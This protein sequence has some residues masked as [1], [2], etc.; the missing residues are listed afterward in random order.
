VTAILGLVLLVAG[1]AVMAASRR[2]GATDE[3]TTAPRG[4]AVFL[5]GCVV[6][7]VG[8]VLITAW[9]RNLSA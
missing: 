7:A 2:V 3:D 6:V 9:W 4:L 1:V 5:A 8:A